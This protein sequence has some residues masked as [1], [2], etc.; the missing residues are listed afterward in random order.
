M[1][2]CTLTANA[3]LLKD[4]EFADNEEIRCFRACVMNYA[5]IVS[6]Y[7]YSY[8]YI[9]QTFHNIVLQIYK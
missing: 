1:D 8:M 9:K 6:K 2:M 7:T 4:D 3:N 5:G